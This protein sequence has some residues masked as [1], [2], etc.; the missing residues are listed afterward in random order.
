MWKKAVI[1]IIIIIIIHH[2]LG[3]SLFRKVP[4]F[5]L[6]AAAEERHENPQSL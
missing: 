1:I 3:H 5:H 2:G 4:S 6:S